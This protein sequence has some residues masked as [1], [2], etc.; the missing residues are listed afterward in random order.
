MAVQQRMLS[1]FLHRSKAF[2]PPPRRFRRFL[3]YASL[4]LTSLALGIY[5]ASHPIFTTVTALLHSPGSPLTYI[6]QSERSAQIDETITSHPL[7][8]ALRADPTWTESRPHLQLPEAMRRHSLTGSTLMG[9]N[10][11][12]VPPLMFTKGQGKELI[13]ISYLGSDLCGHV[14]IIHGG[15]LATMLDEGLAR[16]CFAAL[17][18][19]V[20]VTARLEIDYRK[21]CKSDGFVVL[22]ARTEKVEGRKA[23]VKGRVEVLGVG[24]EVGAVGQGEQKEGL[25]SPFDEIGGNVVV[26]AEGLFVEPKWAKVGG[27]EAFDRSYLLTTGSRTCQNSSGPLEKGRKKRSVPD[28]RAGRRRRREHSGH[29]AAEYLRTGTLF[30]Q[31]TP[32]LSK[33]DSS[34]TDNDRSGP[35]RFERPPSPGRH[36]ISTSLPPS[37]TTTSPTP[38]SPDYR[39]STTLPPLTNIP[40]AQNL[41]A[42][43]PES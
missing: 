20:G 42:R 35:P 16:C 27:L 26:E 17:P 23:W 37:K 14:G 5:A 24:D 18:S 25:F 13:A 8:R 32:R 33:I 1:S 11:I 39:D 22:K 40:H 43:V 9:D 15:L 12:V 7:A 10:K 41:L 29:F 3:L 19:K 30:P 36:Y 6:P 21:V 38:S 31:F 2:P 4:S 28:D 34:L